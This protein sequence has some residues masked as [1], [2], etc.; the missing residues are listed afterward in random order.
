MDGA[1]VAQGGVNSAKLQQ[2]HGRQAEMARWD[3]T[4]LP[5]RDDSVDI[6][7]VDLPFGVRCS[8]ASA[9]RKLYPQALKEMGRVVRPG[10][11]AVLM[12]VMKKALVNSIDSRAWHTEALHSSNCGGLIVA[13]V[14]LRRI[15]QGQ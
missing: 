13:V 9:N 4:R 11:R 8:K 15:D 14:V 3:A 12:T 2:L 5:L 7:V 1:A 10:G 6:V